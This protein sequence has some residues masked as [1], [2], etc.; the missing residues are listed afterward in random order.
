MK[1][2]T[3][4]AV[5]VTINTVSS[6]PNNPYEFFPESEPFPLAEDLKDFTSGKQDTG[7]RFSDDQKSELQD[8][9]DSLRK[10][11]NPHHPD[12]AFQQ[13]VKFWEQPDNLA[14]LQHCVNHGLT[15][16]LNG[17]V[18]SMKTV[19]YTA[20]VYVLK[21]IYKIDIVALLT[22]NITASKDQQ[23][24]RAKKGALHDPRLCNFSIADLQTH[25]KNEP[26]NIN[27]VYVGMASKHQVEKF[28]AC[29]NRTIEQHSMFSE[30]ANTEM[31]PLK[32]LMIVDES[33]L[34]EPGT[35]GP[36]A[37][38]GTDSGLDEAIYRLV[39]KSQQPH[40]GYELHTV[41][42]SATL[43]SQLVT[44]TNFWNTDLHPEQVFWLPVDADY[45][46]YRTPTT[47]YDPSRQKTGLVPGDKSANID[48]IADRTLHH[49]Y[50][51]V[52]NRF[53]LTQ[54]ATV[55]LSLGTKI[56]S[57]I[58]K[59]L[60]KV[61]RKKGMK[62]VE[63]IDYDFHSLQ[64]DH[65][66]D[67]VIV[68]QNGNT[69]NIT[70]GPG[71]KITVI[72][73]K[74]TPKVIVFVGGQMI[75]RAMT[76]ECDG[77]SNPDTD[78]IGGY[79][80]LAFIAPSDRTQMQ[81]ILQMHRCWGVRPS[82]KDH[83][84]YV[85]DH[86]ADEIANYHAQDDLL[87]NRLS[88]GPISPGDISQ[89]ALTNRIGTGRINSNM[90]ITRVNGSRMN[91]H[92]NNLSHAQRNLYVTNGYN[93]FPVL[94]QDWSRKLTV[95]EWMLIDL[96]GQ[97]AAIDIVQQHRNIVI[98]PNLTRF[99]R[100]PE[101]Y[102]SGQD[103]RI[104]AQAFGNKVKT[105]VIT[106]WENAHGDRYIY[107]CRDITNSWTVRYVID[108]DNANKPA[109]GGWILDP[110]RSNGKSKLYP[111]N[112]KTLTPTPIGNTGFVPSGIYQH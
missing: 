31:Q 100:M 29:L 97:I 85:T 36:N 35:A 1:V 86:I 55:L 105:D 104:N 2:T 84:V 28:D 88:Q 52:S 73:E 16:F 68:V 5:E 109:P 94:E 71:E 42:S 27:H 33:D 9:H 101:T 63:L 92:I 7:T 60:K 45:K 24:G 53:G 96:G 20:L 44:Y 108:I 6:V 91:A 102:H 38:L 49:Y 56:H 11:H 12:S 3:K 81:A 46:G 43:V 110:L 4:V 25:S 48:F 67:V 74:C 10:K 17:A 21:N 64:I 54:I 70:Q 72:L 80:N 19:Y 62:K 37:K 112:S 65:D 51:V 111:P 89:W 61:Y 57:D 99:N 106:V 13:A 58:A 78:R 95:Q 34:V 107:H 32:V 82:W 30:M 59:D 40:S 103:A 79:A 47:S 15:L 75:N 93:G 23:H 41:N 76:F 83:V 90:K 50:D 98:D 14:R 26:L 39:E 77:W 69:T 22:N 8:Y 66:T 18:Q 87:K